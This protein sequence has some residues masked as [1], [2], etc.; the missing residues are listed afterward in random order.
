M[1]LRFSISVCRNIDY[2]AVFIQNG[3]KLWAAHCIGQG[4]V[5]EELI[6]RL[7][8]LV[9]SE[10]LEVQERSSTGLHLLRYVS[11]QREK[12]EVESVKTELE[13]FFAGELNPVA[14]KAQRKVPVP[15][16]LDLDAWINEPEVE[17]EDE[18]SEDDM[19]SL[20]GQV[21]TRHLGTPDNCR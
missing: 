16:G 19:K 12:G 8:L 2:Q 11:K 3:L 15:E 4:D 17:E 6:Q 10:A 9:G 20:G 18:D 21:K 14:P 7:E 1:F 13:T 5:E